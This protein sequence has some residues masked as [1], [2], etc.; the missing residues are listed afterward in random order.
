MTSG[1]NVEQ[2]GVALES[3][4]AEL[5]KL[6]P[7]GFELSYVTFQADVVK[8][9]MGKMNQV[10]IET[11]VIVLGVVVLFLGMAHR[12]ISGMIVPLTILGALIVM[13]ALNIELQSVSMAAII[14]ALGLLVDNGI[15]IAEDIERRLAAGEDRKQACLE[16]G[17]TL[18]LPLLTSSLVI[19][20]AFSPFFF[21][22][23][24]TSEYLRSLVIVLARLLG[25]WLLCLTVTPLLCYHFT[26]V[27][28][29]PAND[30]QTYNTRFYRGYRKLLE[31]VLDHKAIYV[32]VM[33][34]ALAV[35]LYGFTT[36]PYNFCRSPTGFN[37]KYQ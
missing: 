11:I 16:A 6:L 37:S 22:Q 35:A 33:T 3:R 28:H 10:M 8:R 18:A 26:K 32:G 21:G 14:I 7:A 24:A 2:F 27:H 9:E 1:Q 4:V 13:R 25:S 5:E 34:G 31:W 19:V 12:F 20:I 15:V 36:L 23:S 29:Q 17:R 30:A